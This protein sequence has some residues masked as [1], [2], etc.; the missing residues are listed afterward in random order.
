[1]YI[2]KGDGQLLAILSQG[3]GKPL[4]CLLLAYRIMLINQAGK[5]RD[6]HVTITLPLEYRRR[7]ETAVKQ[8]SFG[9]P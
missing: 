4:D 8:E 6:F 9:D 2:Y 3:P 1:M 5:A 7:V